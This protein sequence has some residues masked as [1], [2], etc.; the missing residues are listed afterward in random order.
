[1]YVYICKYLYILYLHINFFYI[2]ST[3]LVVPELQ[4]ELDR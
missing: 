2:P 3:L 1:M 4:D